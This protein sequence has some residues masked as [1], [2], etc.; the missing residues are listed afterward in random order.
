[1]KV[2]ILL[3]VLICVSY[4]DVKAPYSYPKPQGARLELPVQYGSPFRA[5][6]NLNVS[7]SC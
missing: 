3:S 5:P 6:E 4:A 1:M 7:M 2:F